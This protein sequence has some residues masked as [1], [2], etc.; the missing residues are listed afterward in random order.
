MINIARLAEE[1]AGLGIVGVAEVQRR[2]GSLRSTFHTRPDGLV[3]VNWPDEP[4][5]QNF[6]AADAIVQAHD[7]S[8]TE[9][10][11]M[12]ATNT[13]QRVLAA[14]ILQASPQWSQIPQQ[15]QQRIMEIIDRAAA[16]ILGRLN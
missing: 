13:E 9:S 5:P 7:G 4:T 10:E 2:H 12:D 1:M 11:V 16:D 15:R 6:T 8:P 14:L 3:R